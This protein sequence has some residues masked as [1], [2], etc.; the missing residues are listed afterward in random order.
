MVQLGA[1]LPAAADLLDE[2]VSFPDSCLF[3]R[4]HLRLLVVG[5]DSGV[6]DQCGF[7]SRVRWFPLF[8]RIVPACLT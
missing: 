7:T 8:S 3:Q 2:E 4:G 6:A 5:G 1:I